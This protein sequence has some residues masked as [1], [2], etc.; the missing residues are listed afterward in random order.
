MAAAT[1]DALDGVGAAVGGKTNDVVPGRAH[2][3]VEAVSSIHGVVTAVAFHQEQ[4][5]ALAAVE[6]IVSWAAIDDVVACITINDVVA[7]Q[8]VE[9]VVAGGAVQRFGTG[10]SVDGGVGRARDDKFEHVRCRQFARI[11]CGYTHTDRTWTGGNTAEGARYC[12]ETKPSRQRAAIS[13]GGAVRQR[14]ICVRVG[15]GISRNGVAERLAFGGRLVWQGLRQF[16][17]VVYRHHAFNNDVKHVRYAETAH[18]FGRH[19]DA[20]CSSHGRRAAEGARC[21][22]EAE[23]RRQWIAIRQGGAVSQHVAR[24]RIGEGIQCDGVAECCPRGCCLVRQRLRQ[25]G[26]VVHRHHVQH[27][28]D[29]I[30]VPYGAVMKPD[31]FD[32]IGRDP[33]ILQIIPD[34]QDVRCPVHTQDQVVPRAGRNYFFGCDRSIKLH[35]V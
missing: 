35:N 29:G 33:I 13:Q 22:I 14:V 16:G 26:C 4:V 15:E 10:G 9:D 7:R 8:A 1:I 28:F 32:R 18:I 25:L 17:G 2:D 6:G 11:F 20:V 19:G 24:V 3:L 30:K 23:P 34:G 5:V 21:S 31:L 12:I 27:A